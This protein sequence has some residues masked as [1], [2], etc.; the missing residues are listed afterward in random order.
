M[1]TFYEVNTNVVTNTIRERNS[2]MGNSIV[3]RSTLI[4]VDNLRVCYPFVHCEYNLG[5]YNLE[6]CPSYRNF[7]RFHGS[8]HPKH[9]PIGQ[10]SEHDDPILCVGSSYRM[11]TYLSNCFLV[12]W[13]NVNYE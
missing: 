8:E 3:G 5:L 4:I 1:Q 7:I 9:G 10:V 12:G 6:N 11:G 13:R 2:V